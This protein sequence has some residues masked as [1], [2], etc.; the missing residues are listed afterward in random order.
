[1][2][3]VGISRPLTDATKKVTANSTNVFMRK[4]LFFILSL[5]ALSASA[6][7]DS[8]SEIHLGTAAVKAQRKGIFK[9]LGFTTN[10]ETISGAE[11]LRAACCNL[12]ESFITNPSVDVNY[13]DAATGSQQIRLLGLAGTYVQMLTEN[14]PNFRGIA[15]PFGLDYVPGPWMQS[16]QVSKGTA[17][18][19]NGYEAMTGQINVEYKKPQMPNP[20]WLMINGY[21]DK[22]G[23]VEGNLDATFR[24]KK[25][26]SE[27]AG[28]ELGSWGTT[29]LAHY[30][31]NLM[32]HDANDDG[33]A[34]MPKSERAIL[35]NRWTYLSDKYISQWGIKGLLEKRES[36]QIAHDHSGHE[37]DATSLQIPY[38]INIDTKRLELFGKNAY[39]F[40]HEH[41]SNIALMLSGSYHEHESRYGRDYYSNDQLNLYASLMFET[42]FTK[43]H[44]LSVG[45]S[46]NYDSYD[47]DLG[48]LP[49]IIGGQGQIIG[50][51]T[52]MAGPGRTTSTTETVP[53]AYAQ[54]TY[55]LNDALVIMGGLRVDYSNY[56]GTFVT[57]RAHI[58]LAP[59]QNFVV[60]VSA[61]KGSRAT[62]ALAEN[63]NLLAGSRDL[64]LEADVFQEE[65]WNSGA[66]LTAKWPLGDHL[67]TLDAEY[68]YTN[69]NKQAVIDFDSNPHAVSIYQLADFSNSENPRSYSQVVQVQLAYPFF[70]GF[71]LTAA[72]RWNDVK[73]TYQL[74]QG[75][76]LLE[77]PLQS[78]WKGLVTA[79]YT[80]GLNHWQFDATLA[81]NGKARLPLGW[82]YNQNDG[83]IF[84]E[85]ASQ[86][87]IVD[88][89]KKI[90]KSDFNYSPVF[91][92]LSAQITRNWRQWSV[93][94][95]G[96]NLTNF[97]MKHPIVHA[98][99]PWGEDFDPTMVWGPVD[100]FMIYAGFRFKIMR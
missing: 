43:R 27:G 66:S 2:R 35:M 48:L 25:R 46:V 33:F 14:I 12:G 91:P 93:Y 5:V 37:A 89:G 71:N 74:P 81:V 68:Y 84:S 86:N 60:R 62:H 100:G 88:N 58:K 34:D 39:T 90:A 97:R 92:S 7:N 78:R 70:E 77:K 82:S 52:E 30:D 55:N 75:A 24:L 28:M 49:W 36:G 11:L 59:N 20:D 57:P 21:G 18:V 9:G 41:N 29:V 42:E 31:K 53:G 6:Q 50:L 19:K 38:I 44:S 80:D 98:A 94:V 8:I 45:T 76:V 67:M 17:S 47:E 4:S 22:N 13:A 1:M 54:Y 40:N 51:G 79:T 3:R 56:F 99:H 96:E 85:R 32:S 15:S 16:I 64:K 23:S 61:G 72:Y 73:C 83:Y 26:T 69:F 63:N 10:T 87:L 65:S 95:G